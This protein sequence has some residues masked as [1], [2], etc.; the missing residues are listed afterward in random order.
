MQETRG[1]QR[2]LAAGARRVCACDLAPIPLAPI[3]RASA[4]ARGTLSPNHH[5][6][7]RRTPGCGRMYPR[8]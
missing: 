4:G 1:N 3:V 5:L 2:A 7:A 6:E 8:C